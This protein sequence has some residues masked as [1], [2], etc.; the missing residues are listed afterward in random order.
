MDSLNKPMGVGAILDRSFQLYRKH[1]ATA[2][3]LLLLFVGP[4][5]LLQNL[6]LYNLSTVP[7]L[8]QSGDSFAE[9]LNL[10]VNGNGGATDEPSPGMI[11]FILLVL[12]L[13]AVL[14]APVML[15]SQL[16]LVRTAIEGGEVRFAEVLRKS[17]ARYGRQVGNTFLYGLIVV[18]LLF[19]IWIALVIAIV[20]I[21]SLTVG[22]GA[23]FLAL[24][25]DP[26]GGSVAF[27]I[28]IFVV[29]ILTGL[30]MTACSSFFMIR[31]GFY[32]PIVTLEE[33][34]QAIRRSWRLTRGSF[35]RIFAVYLILSIIY[36]VFSLGAYA[37]LIAV[38]KMS[39]IGQLIN[40]ALI[41]LI[42]PFYTIPYAVIYYDLRVRNEGADLERYLQTS[43]GMPPAAGQPVYGESARA[44][45]VYGVSGGSL[46]GGAAAG[47][48]AAG[49]EPLVPSRADVE[50]AS[51]DGA[52]AGSAEESPEARDAEGGSREETN[53][54]PAPE[55]TDSPKAGEPTSN[56][57]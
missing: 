15:S 11:L 56:D 46:I 29:Y 32:L 26:F 35:W 33:G 19:V 39:L 4:F 40:I 44:G 18:G 9:S 22:V 16:Q 49:L 55:D 38:F 43:T 2:F 21:A 37:L 6:L 24:G 31:F 27:I 17:F 57:D 1:F 14:L 8:P 7:L 42:A 12:P 23:G 41:L 36:S 52:E 34:G 48:T 50:E 5:Y 13:Y 54:S 45:D 47:A 10:F 53:T 51:A 3:L 25:G 30:G 28:I 20:I